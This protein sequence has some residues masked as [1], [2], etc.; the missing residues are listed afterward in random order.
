MS[1]IQSAAGALPSARRAAGVPKAW[2]W[3]LLGMLTLAV[4]LA[5][6]LAMALWHRNAAAD[7][8]PAAPAFDLRYISGGAG[9]LS[10]AALAGHPVLLNFT[11]SQ[12]GPCLDEM[13]TL[14]WAAATF[15]DKG[16]RVISIATQSDTLAAAR[17]LAQAAHVP[18]PML[19]DD[20]A[21]SWQYDVA[22]LPTSFFIDAQGKLHGQISGPLTRETARDGLAQAGAVSCTGC[23]PVEPLGPLAANLSSH[24]LSADFV[25]SP[26]KRASAFALK[27]QNGAVITPASLRGKAVLLT[28][29]SSVC[30][31]QC[32]LVGV[33]VRLVR[34][35][36][37]K[38]SSKL[39][40]VV[41][42]VDPEQDS[43]AHTRA[44]AQEA[45][46][47]G[48]DWDEL[49]APRCVLKPIWAAYGIYVPDPS[50]I[51]KQG[52]SIVHDAGMY[53]L[54]PQGSLRAYFQVPV[55]AT[56]VAAAAK[57]LL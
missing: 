54:D 45:G 12:C 7:G 8:A 23:A 56:R 51:F 21:I 50:P 27:D 48:T 29:L 28:F 22:T 52:T 43:A 6:A 14:K 33:T 19:L 1:T 25:F 11:N 37:G 34:R 44:F 40:V 24:D 13:P 2:R 41:I 26:P 32:P 16:V 49:T 3:L 4:V 36:L 30:T 31:E 35:Q 53:L 17:A 42:S 57:H 15:K 39:S 20:Q 9:Q 55:M 38:D 10:L 46:W 47:Q 18:Y 5:G